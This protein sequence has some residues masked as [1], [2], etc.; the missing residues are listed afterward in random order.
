MCKTYKGYNETDY[1]LALEI[2]N[3]DVRVN[4]VLFVGYKSSAS[5]MPNLVCGVKDESDIRIQYYSSSI[6]FAS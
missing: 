3:N 4:I 5:K 1:L 2:K 6:K